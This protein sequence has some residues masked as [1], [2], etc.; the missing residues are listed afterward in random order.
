MIVDAQAAHS[1]ATRLPLHYDEDLSRLR[2]GQ[3]FD[4]LRLIF[5]PLD[6]LITDD[7]LRPYCWGHRRVSFFFWWDRTMWGENKVGE[8][9]HRW[10]AGEVVESDGRPHELLS[11]ECVYRQGQW[12]MKWLAR[13]MG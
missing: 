8:T 11:A 3:R 5:E 12:C 10:G 13:R 4:R 9:G 7:Y 2:P 1:P 6:D